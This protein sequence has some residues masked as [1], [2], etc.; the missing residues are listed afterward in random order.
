MYAI[1]KTGD[2]YMKQFWQESYF[3]RKNW[4]MENIVSLNLSEREFMLLMLISFFTEQNRLITTESLSAHSNLSI[5]DVDDCLSQLCLKQYL[6]V[7]FTNGIMSFNMDGIFQQKEKDV[8][9]LPIFQTFEQEFGRPLT[10][11]ELMML[12]EWIRKYDNELIIYALREAAIYRKLNIKYIDTILS[13][14]EKQGITV[15][16]LVEDVQRES[17]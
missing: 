13:R 14:W 3:N 6:Q 17:E 16:K 8:D 5:Q 15:E 10:Q 11:K 12:S 4:L 9:A 2:F 1:I 7:T